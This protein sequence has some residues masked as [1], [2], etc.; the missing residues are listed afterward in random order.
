MK[1][2]ILTI[3]LSNSILFFLLVPLH[4]FSHFV[5]AQF[6]GCKTQE[7]LLDFLASSAHA[8]ILCSQEKIHFV[9]LGG[10]FPAILSFPFLLS[11]KTGRKI[12]LLVTG[13]S[14]VLSSVDLSFLNPSY[15]Y[16][17]L[18]TGLFFISAGEYKVATNFTSLE[19]LQNR[20]F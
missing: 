14:F 11:G 3:V 16:F 18:F 19:I 10:L 15:F 17:S 12:F 13:F 5:I 9:Y 8:K 1:K 4:E 20:S 7:I 2:G 6:L